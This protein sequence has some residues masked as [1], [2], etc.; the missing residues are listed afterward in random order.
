MPE[1]KFSENPVLARSRVDNRK[2]VNTLE[3]RNAAGVGFDC[4]DSGPETQERS[5]VTS[6]VRPDVEY[7]VARINKLL[8][9]DFEH[10]N[11]MRSYHRSEKYSQAP[12]RR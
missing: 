1:S 4:H 12:F 6:D 7:E 10:Q 5:R 9:E 11:L 3:F 8:V 2:S